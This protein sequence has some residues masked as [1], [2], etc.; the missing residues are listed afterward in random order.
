MSSIKANRHHYRRPGDTGE[1]TSL[2]LRRNEKIATAQSS[3]YL[4][5]VSCYATACA[6]ERDGKKGGRLSAMARLHATLL[7]GSFSAALL[8]A[9]FSIIGPCL[10]GVPSLPGW[11][12]TRCLRIGYRVTI[13]QHPRLYCAQ[14][15]PRTS[16]AFSGLRQLLLDLQTMLTSAACLRSSRTS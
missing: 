1:E 6:A 11:L 13:V 4:F 8:S 3:M 15:W 12:Y 10:S 7:L 5:S 14:P 16:W 9:A 2:R